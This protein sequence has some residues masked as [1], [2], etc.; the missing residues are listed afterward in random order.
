MTKQNFPPLNDRA[1]K[2]YCILRL[3]FPPNISTAC[4]VCRTVSRLMNNM[5][6]PPPPAP[7]PVGALKIDSTDASKI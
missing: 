1:T 6:D 3:P 2:K 4:D 5:S 7:P